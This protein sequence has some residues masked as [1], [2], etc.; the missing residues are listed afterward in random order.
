MRLPP[1]RTVILDYDIVRALRPQVCNNHKLVGFCRECPAC[2]AFEGWVLVEPKSRKWKFTDAVTGVSLDVSRSQLPIMPED[3]CS[4]YALQG[5]TCDPGLVAHFAK[6]KRVDRD[7]QWLIIYVLLSRVRSLS[8][9]R[10]VGLTD[11]DRDIIEGG[12][13][14]I[15]TENFEKLFRT[16]IKHTKKAAEAAL[17]ALG[18]R[19]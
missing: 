9:L 5:A 14:E 4:L 13:P 3:A 8:R 17:A 15:L 12:A 18:W 1:D 2:R 6:P 16:K 10:S 11:K 7:M 19:R